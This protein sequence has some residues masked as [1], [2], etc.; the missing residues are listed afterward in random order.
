MSANEELQSTN[1]ELQSVN[2]ELYTVN[3]EYQEKLAEIS[4][5]NN[6]LD[7]VLGLSQIGIIF[8]D[9]NLLI[10]RYTQAVTRYINLMDSDVHRPLH[11]ISSNINYDE[12]I[13]DVAEVFSQG[14]PREREIV[15][16]DKRV[17]RVSINP[18]S[19]ADISQSKG[20]AVT[21]SDVSDARYNE[22][23][24]SVAYKKLRTS[25]NNALGLL[26]KNGLMTE[27]NALV[28]SNN[29]SKCNLIEKELRKIASF[30]V[31]IKQSLTVRSALA[32]LDDQQIDICI[33]EHNATSETALD[34]LEALNKKQNQVPIVVVTSDNEKYLRAMLLSQ[35]AV[36]FI[37]KDDLNPQMLSR[38][39]RFAIL[40]HQI[41]QQTDGLLLETSN[42][43]EREPALD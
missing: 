12:L 5:A 20:V 10:R 28:V 21:F 19:Y 30:A 14:T 11:H 38:S 31:E 39:V 34:L 25:L 18:Y 36:N 42:E 26:D 8:L 33:L 35:G 37:S 23:G 24:L 13:E 1:E 4:Q 3:S 9:E 17:L 16:D 43:A 7:E 27:V 22:I 41:D 40:K 29:K 6:D 32:A 15:L 2:E